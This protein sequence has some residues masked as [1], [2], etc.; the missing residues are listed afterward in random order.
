MQRGA[1]KLSTLPHRPSIPPACD[2]LIV[3]AGL[4]GLTLAV[5]LGRSGLDVAMLDRLPIEHTLAAG[6]D[7]RVTAIAYSSWQLLQAIGAW[8]GMAV[9]AQPMFDIRVTDGSAPV[10]LN[11]D[12]RALG[13]EPFGYMVENRHIRAA[14]LGE[15]EAM[16]TVSLIAPATLDH[17]AYGPGRA[18][19]H[20]DAGGK[21]AASLVLAADGRASRLRE[22]AGIGTI[23]H[24]YDQ[25]G[26]V[27]TIEHEHDHR[28]IAHERFLTPGPFA[29]LPLVGRRSS[30]VWSEAPDTAKALLTLDDDGFN[31]Q[32]AK[33]IGGFL[34]D[35]RA[36]GP[37]FSYP[38]A[39]H[40]ADRFVDERLALIGD[41][42]H[43]I[44]PIAGQ[45]LNLGWRD[46][47]ALA[48]LVVD[49]ARLGLDVGSGEMLARY[50]RWRRVD[51]LTLAA[52][53]DGLNALFSNDI[54]PVRLARDAG[55]AV[56]NR[57]DPLKK[58]F[59]EHA[60]GTV[61]TLPRLL[62]GESLI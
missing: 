52:V 47:A 61:G 2:V 4:S 41:A 50:D 26:I 49:T 24:R 35:V 13:D 45:G 18:R 33:R 9:H 36:V 53:T 55:L 54:A 3:G 32:I 11:F 10:F 48:E 14:L 42:A 25:A 7:G 58:L 37:R 12:H 19:A 62:K 31:A 29:I 21:I 60:R 51:S 43:G 20:L 6:F 44:H 1:E 28:G 34:G 17:I 15:I 59:M 40:V 57:I 56:V 5:A 30:L 22:E 23:G 16:D 27:T 46:V 39:V 8:E 38:Y